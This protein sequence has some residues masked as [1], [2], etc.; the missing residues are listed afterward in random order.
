VSQQQLTWQ[1]KLPDH[2]ARY[3]HGFYGSCFPE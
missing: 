2:A 1:Y 3:T